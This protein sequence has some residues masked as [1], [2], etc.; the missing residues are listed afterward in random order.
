MSAVV[1]FAFPQSD[2]R[3]PQLLISLLDRVASLGS[4]SRNLRRL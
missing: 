4:N 3:N 2:F 1:E